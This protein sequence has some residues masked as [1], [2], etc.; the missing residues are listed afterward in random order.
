MPT[1]VVDLSHPVVDGA[2]AIGPGTFEGLDLT[3]RAV[4][5]RTGWSARFGQADYADG[6]PHLTAGA[7]ALLAASGCAVVGID[8]PN[9]DATATGARP[10]HTALLAAGIPIVEH[11]TNLASL[12]RE[13]FS[14]TALPLAFVGLA[15]SPVRAVAAIPA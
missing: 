6:H 12:P 13:G 1:R 15:T 14:F 4:L 3:D 10:V 8:S 7:G 2:G 9:V 11:L 5:V